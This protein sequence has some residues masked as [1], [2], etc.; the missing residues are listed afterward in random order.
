MSEEDLAHVGEPFSTTKPP[1]SEIGLGVFFAR[2]FAERLGGRLTL[3]STRGVGTRVV[4]ELP[5]TEG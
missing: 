3:G 5:L 1:G 2:A 4:L